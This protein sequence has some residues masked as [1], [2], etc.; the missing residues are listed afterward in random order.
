M[1]SVFDCKVTHFFCNLQELKPLIFR[2]VGSCQQLLDGCGGVFF[3]VLLGAHHVGRLEE[4]LAKGLVGGPHHLSDVS[5][6]LFLRACVEIL[7]RIE[8]EQIEADA[9][10][11][12]VVAGHRLPLVGGEVLQVER[13]VFAKILVEGDS[14]AVVAYDDAVVEGSYLCIDDGRLDVGQLLDEPSEGDVQLVVDVVHVG[15]LCLGIADEHLQR[16]VLEEGEHATVDLRVVNR[17]ELQHVLYQRAR[18]HGIV[19]RHLLQ[20]GI[21]ASGEVLALQP[22]VSFHFDT[23]GAVVVCGPQPVFTGAEE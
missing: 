3:H 23:M 10:G 4:P 5:V 13:I 19:G 14:E 15:I 18:L 9:V 17:A 21:V 12:D 7:Q 1:V 11:H 16:R 2:K 22:V 20:G 6:A 8:A